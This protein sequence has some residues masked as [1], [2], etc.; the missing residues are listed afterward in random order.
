[1]EHLLPIK[2]NDQQQPHSHQNQNP[3]TPLTDYPI[4]LKSSTLVNA[5]NMDPH[6][7]H[8]DIEIVPTAK[9][10]K[11]GVAVP[12]PYRLYIL[13]ELMDSEA[14]QQG[15]GKSIVGWQP[16]GRAFKVHNRKI[17]EES[18][19]PV[20]FKQTRYASFQRQLNLYG[21]LRLTAPGPDHG[22]VYHP[23]FVR[24]QEVLLPGVVRQKIKGT[25]IRR[26]GPS[27][28]DQPN[29][30]ASDRGDELQLRAIEAHFKHHQLQRQHLHQQQSPSKNGINGRSNTS[31]A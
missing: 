16:H 29:F 25:R 20:H 9:I 6:H 5:E 4:H 15:Q 23:C 28:D 31:E 1:M 30:Y 17:F 22:A 7:Q 19:L 10:A 12:F 8:T 14:Q 3:I 26:K 11:G 18:I 24:G 21:F 27:P 13:L 2:S